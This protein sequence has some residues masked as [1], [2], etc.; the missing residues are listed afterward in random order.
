MHNRLFSPRHRFIKGVMQLTAVEGILFPRE[1]LGI[2]RCTNKP[3]SVSLIIPL[4]GDP[5]ALTQKFC[6]PLEGISPPGNRRLR[7]VYMLSD[8]GYNF[9]LKSKGNM[10]WNKTWIYIKMINEVVLIIVNINST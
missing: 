3:A 5:T 2:L 8:W 10:I 6:G 9:C 4:A 1:I 7:T